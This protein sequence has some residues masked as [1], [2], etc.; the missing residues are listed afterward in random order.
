MSG[1][2]KS[3]LVYVDAEGMDGPKLMGTLHAQSTGRQGLNHVDDVPRTIV[4][5]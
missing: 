1:R 3:V 4:L 2:Q 5:G